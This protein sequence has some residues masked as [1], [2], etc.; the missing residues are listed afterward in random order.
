MTAKHLKRTLPLTLV[1]ATIT[2]LAA[3]SGAQAAPEAPIK[4]VLSSHFGAEVDMT[5]TGN[6]CTVESKD[7]CQ[8][9]KSSSEPG[10]FG[11]PEGPGPQ[12]VAVA[13]NGNVYVGDGL[14][15]RVQELKPNG[16]F[17]LMFGREVNATTKGDIC[18]AEEVKSLHVKCKAGVVG[19]AAG[20]FAGILSVTVDPSI[21]NVYVKDRLN[22]RVQE[23]TSVGEF[24]LMI[25][26]EVNETKDHTLGATTAEKNVCTAASKDACKAGEQNLQSNTE[27]G[28][29]NFGEG[30]LAAGGP[31]DLLY[32]GDEHWV[33]EFKAD[34]TWVGE[35]P[36][37]SISS[38]PGS[39]VSALT[40]DQAGDVYLVY[41]V[42][43]LSNTI[44]EFNSGGEEVK[45]IELSPRETGTIEEEP[46]EVVAIALDPAGRLAVTEHERGF[47][48]GPQ[49]FEAYRGSLYEIAPTNLHLITEFDAPGRVVDI[50]F[51]GSDGLY[52]AGQPNSSG[53][54]NGGDEVLVY[55]PVPVAELLASPAAC[56]AG[57]DSEIGATV[58]CSLNGEANPW[59]VSETKVS[60]HWGK[61]TALGSETPEQGV[62]AGSVPVQ[63][64]APLAG[65]LPN[66]TYYA[67][68]VGFDH[69][70]KPPERALGSERVSFITPAVPPT[71]VG[72]PSVSFIG[73]FSAVLSGGLNPE[74]AST[75]YFFEY[76]RCEQLAGCG[77]A[78][79]TAVLKSAVY[80]RIGTN[81]EA[82]GLQPVSTYRYRLVTINALQQRV[83]GPEESFTT[84]PA[85]AP[86]PLVASGP[87][88]VGGATAV[89]PSVLSAPV[90]LAQ[91]PVPNIAF[92]TAAPPAKAKAAPKKA[93][94]KTKKAKRKKTRARKTSAHGAQRHERGAL[95]KRN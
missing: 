52:A 29:F 33:Q 48:E 20:Q 34:G 95:S 15:R 4:E 85:P 5:T 28:A 38:S 3:V 51:D 41:N 70:V 26:K 83:E 49:A 63:V 37:T 53:D 90:P 44:R 11:N 35:I 50:A 31:K 62:A 79:K 45:H 16:E 36:L 61:S 84:A 81:L 80:G 18:T 27:P 2:L 68:L 55:T 9:G 13:G 40:V 91:L 30:S 21:G 56:V 59:G 67:Q 43:S 64:S 42:S 71:V 46:S 6:I 58:D 22:W 94:K 8:P 57:P 89:V 12:G 74:N 7:T 72:E 76:G 93:K 65:L 32:V 39:Y 69:N 75:E 17:V 73:P 78:L 82:T 87:P 14:N 66:E 77:A 25:G 86:A 92:P 10:G 60:F 88:S 47:K 24:V 23:F 19:A 1:A 54:G